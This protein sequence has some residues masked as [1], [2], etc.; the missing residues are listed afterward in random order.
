M[1][2]TMNTLRMTLLAASL[3]LQCYANSPAGAGTTEGHF[4]GTTKTELAGHG[5]QLGTKPAEV[6]QPILLKAPGDTDRENTPQF[7]APVCH[8]LCAVYTPW[9]LFV[10]IFYWG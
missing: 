4:S 9:Q 8:G 7:V 3:T 5:S 1:N 6:I 10:S 2:R